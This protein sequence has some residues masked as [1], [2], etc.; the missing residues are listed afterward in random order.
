MHICII[1][2]EKSKSNM[3]NGIWHACLP[4]L[5]HISLWTANRSNTH[6]N[7]QFTIKIDTN[8]AHTVSYVWQYVLMSVLGADGRRLKSCNRK[9]MT[10]LQT[11]KET[12]NARAREMWKKIF[13]LNEIAHGSSGWQSVCHGNGCCNDTIHNIIFVMCTRDV[14]SLSLSL[15]ERTK[16]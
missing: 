7:T 12:A 1:N 14:I 4:F 10:S 15:C 6:C 2:G 16:R 9:I 3:R 11:E 8:M 13:Q 5:A